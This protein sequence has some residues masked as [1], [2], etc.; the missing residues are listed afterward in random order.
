MQQRSDNGLMKS[1]ATGGGLGRAGWGWKQRSCVKRAGKA[2]GAG[3]AGVAGCAWSGVDALESRMLLGADPFPNLGDMEDPSNPILRL[4][5]R[6]GAIDIEVLANRDQ[7]LADAYL[8]LFDTPERH[9]TLF[10]NLTAGVALEA[11]RWTYLDANDEFATEPAGPFTPPSTTPSANLA[12]TVTTLARPVQSPPFTYM[13]TVFY[14]NLQDNAPPAA[15]GEYAVVARVLGDAAWDVVQTI[16]GLMA[17]DF[18]EDSPFGNWGF[19]TPLADAWTPGTPVTPEDMVQIGDVQVIKAQ[20]TT[21]FYAYEVYSV[22]GFTGSTINEYVPIE[23]PNDEEVFYEVWARY[24]HVEERPWQRDQLIQR[25]SIAA[26]SRGGVTV[27]T[28]DDWE[29]AAVQHGVPYAI[30]VRSTLPVAATL[31]HYDFGAATGES[32]TAQTDT[33]WTFVGLSSASFSRSFLLWYN[34]TDEAVNMTLTLRGH[35]VL[36]TMTF[37]VTIDAY[38]R[39]GIDL[40]TLNIDE[41]RYSATLEA[42]GAIVAQLTSYDVVEMF[43][44]GAWTSLGQAGAAS[45]VGVLPMVVEPNGGTTPANWII[46]AYNPG[47]TT[48]TVTLD[49]FVPG[50]SSPMHSIVNAMTIEP[51]DVEFYQPTF[52]PASDVPLTVVYRSSE[53]IHAISEVAR[54]E[55]RYRTQMAVEAGQQYHFAEGFTDPSRTARNVLEEYIY[56]FNPNSTTFGVADQMATLSITFRYTDGTTFS[57]PLTVAAGTTEHLEL[58][59]LQELIDQADLHDRYFYS[60]QVSSDVPIIAQ[61]LHVDATLGDPD[62]ATGGF[63]TL[64][65][66]FGARTR[67]DQL[68]DV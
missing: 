68:G 7:V 65:T 35:G 12:R 30:E 60:V 40:G 50:S 49:F 53:A 64:G 46:K 15:A 31:S 19:L 41:F 33:N 56:V 26:N 58:S 20:G 4:E 10:H 14:F 2:A 39:G 67:L 43:A 45:A 23:N 22:E 32:F 9:Q 42:D 61:M 54:A 37:P 16:A 1:D 25:G 24:E 47:A 8:Q 57:I 36:E 13:S 66:V 51:G 27:S 18:E 11:G 63:T 44:E 48:V 3:R 5:T 6:Y 38:R 52:D 21:E 59:A 62:R 28:V 34:P 55:D 29:Q 17:V